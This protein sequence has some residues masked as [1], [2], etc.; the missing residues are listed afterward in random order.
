[1][2][3][4]ANRHTQSAIVANC[5][6]LAVAL[7]SDGQIPTTK[8]A[9]IRT[10]TFDNDVQTAKTWQYYPR[11]EGGR[12]VGYENNFTAGPILYTVDRTGRH[13]DTQFVLEGAASI[14]VLQVA[15]SAKNE[16]AVVGDAVTSDLRGSTFLARLQPGGR[17]QI[18]TRT[19]PYA[20][21]AVVFAPDDTIWTIGNQFTEDK[22]RDVA[23]HVLRRF[24]CNGKEL[25]SRI[26]NLPPGGT[27]DN[28]SYLGAAHDRI[29]WFTTSGLYIEFALD[30]K[31]LA[32]YDGPGGVDQSGD[33]SNWGNR[34]M[35]LSE[36]G[37][38]LVAVTRDKHTALYTLIRET[39]SWVKVERESRSQAPTMLLGFDGPNLVT[40]A[41]RNQDFRRLKVQ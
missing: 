39:R 28:V 5:L 41:A 31:E 20:P 2:A 12:L 36:D 34:S 9:P 11:W 23:Y 7:V 22:S 38:V 14:I 29:G 10:L 37:L 35:A 1:M 13:E 3:F 40:T 24:D 17:S 30:G 27:T 16:I 4:C 6:L 19:F 15:A 32:R 18:V 21:K 8:K 33:S 25:S 26:L